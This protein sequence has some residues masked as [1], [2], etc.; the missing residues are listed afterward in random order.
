[1]SWLEA[2]D[3]SKLGMPGNY[4]EWRDSQRR[5]I[6]DIY[7]DENRISVIQAP[8]GM[9][10]SGIGVALAKLLKGRAVYLTFTKAL[11]KQLMTDFE[12]AGMKLMMGRNNYEC[13]HAPTPDWDCDSWKQFCQGNKCGRGQHQGPCNAWSC[14]T[15]AGTCCYRQQFQDCIESDLVCTN[16]AYWVNVHKGGTGGLS[17]ATHPIDL[18]VLDEAHNAPD[19]LCDLLSVKLTSRDLREYTNSFPE[20]PD[21]IESWCTWAKPELARMV[22]DNLEQRSNIFAGSAA[23][24]IARERFMMKLNDIANHT[25]EWAVDA[26]T[27]PKSWSFTPVSAYEHAA[28]RLFLNAKKILIMSGTLTRKTISMLGVKTTNYDYHTYR[29]AFPAKNSR[30]YHVKTARITYRSKPEDIEKLFRT[31]ANIIRKRANRSGIIHTVSYKR[32]EEFLDWL[33]GYDMELFRL[34]MHH[35]RHN[36]DDVVKQ[37]KR[38]KNPRVLVSPSITTGYDFPQQ[39]CEYVI[40]MKLPFPMTQ[41]N[42]M[43]TRVE[44]DKSYPGYLMSQELVQGFGRGM[45]SH[46]DRCEVF[47]LDDNWLWAKGLYRK[48]LPAWVKVSTRDV[49]P[50]A[51]LSIAQRLNSDVI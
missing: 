21:Q 39:E 31:T 44:R 32:S 48:F 26:N 42:V 50:K 34:T 43:K 3:P 49:V 17:P 23:K 4:T 12:P 13:R 36:T 35:Q 47:I 24:I 25:G 6:E 28:S 1:M 18:L 8:V 14:D 29:Y 22:Q 46:T 30:I 7:D 16:Y 5:A 19:G 51:P 15:W 38:S 20:E 2:I 33:K 37:F 40:W 41:S 11:Q 45:R 9:G 27:K 10:K